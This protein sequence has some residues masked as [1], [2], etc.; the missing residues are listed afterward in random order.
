[1]KPKN[2]KYL[3]GVLTT[4]LGLYTGPINTNKVYA[5]N[6]ASIKVMYEVLPIRALYVDKQ[7]NITKI[8]SNCP[9][10]SDERL[11]VFKNG[12]ETQ[13]NDKIKENYHKL[14]PTIDWNIPKVHQIKPEPKLLQNNP[15]KEREVGEVY[16]NLEK[17][18]FNN[19][20]KT[21]DKEKN[22]SSSEE[23]WDKVK[24]LNLPQDKKEYQIR[25]TICED[26]ISIEHIKS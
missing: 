8:L 4:A 22:M 26:N 6:T 11:Q 3:V 10:I 2:L 23:I 21:V 14:L 1:M 12:I 18:V 19:I 15:P 7:D 9:T 16:S 24:K 17:A 25:V 13:M 20:K 5:E